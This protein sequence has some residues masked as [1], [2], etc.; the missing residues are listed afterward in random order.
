MKTLAMFPGQGSQEPYMGQTLAKE[1][2]HIM[3]LWLMAEEYSG[4]PLRDIYWSDNVELMAKTETL[5]P[6]L[7]IC[8]LGLWLK[9][10][11]SLIVHATTGHSLG[12]FTALAASACLST[13]DTLKAVCER[14]KI[15]AKAAKKE[16]GMAAI[17]KLEREYIEEIV[18][19]TQD[20]TDFN[21]FIANY[22]S[23]SQ[24][25]ISG[26]KEALE[27]ISTKLKE[28]KKGRV[29][30]LPVSGAF[31][32][33]LMQSAAE[34][35]SLVLDSLNWKKAEI[36]FYSNVTANA[37]TDIAEIKE[38]MKKQMIAPV[39]WVELLSNLYES[40]FRIFCEFGPKNVL[41]KLTSGTL[42]HEDVQILTHGE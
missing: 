12:E 33:P 38:S 26:E 21:V 24:T 31:H 16:H 40:D 39:R 20:N 1:N 5:Q 3:D 37:A 4:L 13:E 32:S 2:S 9:H 30:I 35:F 7:T 18:K 8:S 41:S 27:F 19:H 29:I 15:M 28:E 36:P 34:E 6:A 23:P 25:V 22:N 11:D 14:G 10:K 42:T 17:L